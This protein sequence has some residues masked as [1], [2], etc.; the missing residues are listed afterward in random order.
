MMN[1]SFLGF[2]G[3]GTNNSAGIGVRGIA[4]SIIFIT[5]Y[6]PSSIDFSLISG[7]I[8]EQNNSVPGDKSLGIYRHRPNAYIYIIIQKVIEVKKKIP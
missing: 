7:W 1:L 3:L 8:S 2:C 6:L 5:N 4:E